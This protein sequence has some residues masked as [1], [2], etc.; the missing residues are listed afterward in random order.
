MFTS[1][2]EFRLAL[3]ADNAD[4][5]LT[6]LGLQL[7]CVGP[8]RQERFCKKREALQGAHAALSSRTLTPKEARDR[9]IAVSQD[10]KKRTAYD[11]LAFPDVDFG[12]LQQ[13]WPELSEIDPDI[14]TQ[15]ARDAQYAHYIDRQRED[16]AA[17]QRDEAHVIPSNFDY[18]A[19]PGLSNEARQKLIRVRPETLGQAGRIEGMTPAA[20]TLI[21]AA[22]RKSERLRQ[23]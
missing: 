15:V 4:Q 22:L 1:R 11:F 10:G 7:G 17:L 19:L 20:L 6:P 16:V 9:G 3:R 18:E 21:L 8:V 2:A 23:A 5:R 13:I 12:V 14:R